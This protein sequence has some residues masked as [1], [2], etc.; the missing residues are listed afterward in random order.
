MSLHDWMDKLAR[1]LGLPAWP[2]EVQSK[3]RELYQRGFG[4]RWAAHYLSLWMDRPS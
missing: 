4:T 2:P 1:M 3:A